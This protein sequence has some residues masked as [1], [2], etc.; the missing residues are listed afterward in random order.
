LS[1]TGYLVGKELIHESISVNVVHSKPPKYKKDAM[2]LA[3]DLP[4]CISDHWVRAL[5]IVLLEEIFWSQ[6]IISALNPMR[7]VA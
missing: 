1:T 6:E 4:P 2:I 3:I 7:V 5:P